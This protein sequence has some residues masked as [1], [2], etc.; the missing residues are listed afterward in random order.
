MGRGP[1]H[2]LVGLT[3]D[4]FCVIYTHLKTSKTRKLIEDTTAAKSPRLTG[5]EWINLLKKADS[6][7]TLEQKKLWR[8]Q[9]MRA[10]YG[11]NRGDEYA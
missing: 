11:D 7:K 2:Y 9:A 4:R 10:F 1:P 6:A 8:R 3:K 5:E